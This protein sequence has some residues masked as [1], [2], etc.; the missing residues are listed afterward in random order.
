[1]PFLNNVYKL[2]MKNS[3]NLLSCFLVFTFLFQCKTDKKSNDVP[4]TAVKTNKSLEKSIENSIEIRKEK[5]ENIATPIGMVWISGGTIN[6]GAVP[7][8][9][10]AMDHEKPA[11]KVAVDGF[12]MD[13]TEVTNAQFKKFVDATGYET[14]AERPIDWEEI[15]KQLPVD[16]PRPND[17]IMQPGSLTFKK[18]KNVVTNR[19][20][21]SQ[22][23]QWTIGANWKNPEGPESSI[24]GKEAQPVVHIAYEDAQ[25]YCKWAGRRLPT[26]AEWERAAR[27]NNEDTI[28]FWG[29]DETKL[30]AMANS[31]EGQ[32]PNTNTKAD[33]FERR[34]PVK[35]YAPN[36]FGLYDMAGN[37]WEWTSDWY[38]TRYYQEVSNRNQVLK[39][40]LGAESP[41]NERDP[42]AREKV[43][44]GGS[45]LCNASYC[46]S[47][48]ISARMATSLDSSLEHLGFRTV[49]TLAML[50]TSSNKNKL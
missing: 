11:H 12:F 49:A 36:D 34:A 40:P 41:R 45:F 3:L 43:M 15:K 37:V 28:F 24:K 35:S 22:W 23:W 17:S 14:V 10:M 44:K 13:I 18:T 7:Q 42:Y 2:I 4:R 8:D 27:G 6:K 26:E 48:R 25:A 32:F 33:G 5:P 20:D 9:K 1:M 47:Y 16:T 31:W 50:E 39:N 46:A 38:N 19:Y 29:D 30:A 21:F